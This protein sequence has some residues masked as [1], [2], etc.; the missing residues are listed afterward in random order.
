MHC[1][2][3]GSRESRARLGV[4]VQ[5]PGQ[6][7]LPLLQAQQIGN[8]PR[9]FRFGRN[10]LSKVS[11]GE[12]FPTKHGVGDGQAITGIG[13]I[14]PVERRDPERR[15]G[16]GNV[17]I[18]QEG[19]AFLERASCVAGQLPAIGSFALKHPTGQRK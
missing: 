12:V 2:L 16:R 17:A 19:P 7:N 14:G 18:S 9:F 8:K 6:H 3:M 11:F 1:R 10:G 15:N 13:S 5:L 4:F